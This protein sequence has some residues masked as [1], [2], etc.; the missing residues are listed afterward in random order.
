VAGRLV[1]V[2]VAGGRPVTTKRRKT[3]RSCQ[4]DGH[5]FTDVNVKNIT[6]SRR[7]RW[8]MFYESWLIVDI[9]LSFGQALK[10]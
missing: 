3:G 10:R 2:V 5:W 9:A 1:F 6:L 8:I 4:Y 7:R